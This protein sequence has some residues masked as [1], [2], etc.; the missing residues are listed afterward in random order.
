MG[1]LRRF[2]TELGLLSALV[3]MGTLFAATSPHFAT[4]ANLMQI[5]VDVAVIGIVA[6]GEFF[7]IVG[8]GIDIS[9]GKTAAL[10]GV[11]AAT[12]LECGAGPLAAM[13]A[14]VTTGAAVGG[15]NG[16]LANAFRIPPFIVTLGSFS[17]AEGLTLVWTRGASVPVSELGWLAYLGQGWIFRTVPVP[18]VVTL[19][20]FAAGWL[21]AARSLYG[22]RLYATGGNQEAARLAGIAVGRLRATAYV[23][24]GALAGLGGLVIMSQ[25]GAG[26]PN[27]GKGLEFDSITAVVLGGTSLYGGEGNLVSVLVGAIFMGTL[28]NGLTQWNVSS[29]YQSMIKGAVLITAVLL[30][31]A[32]RRRARGNP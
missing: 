26:D 1:R 16:I 27:A 32:I 2:R 8:G 20:T 29:Y 24:A 12:L 30:D 17:M 21:V 28:T 5:M 18:V 25:L 10:A 7:V 6:V 19:V 31:T 14:A 22:R 15:F 4:R 3:A 11:V 9:V 23:L 13:A